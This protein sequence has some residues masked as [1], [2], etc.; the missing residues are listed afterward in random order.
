MWPFE[1]LDSINGDSGAVA[2]SQIRHRDSVSASWDA[3]AGGL[4]GV[5]LDFQGCGA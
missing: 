2:L 5:D 4:G 1:A 3:L